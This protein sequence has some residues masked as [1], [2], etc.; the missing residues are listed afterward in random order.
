M[1]YD[2]GE[3]VLEQVLSRGDELGVGLADR[4]LEAKEY[5]QAG[6]VAITAEGFPWPWA[7]VID[8]PLPVS[9]P[10]TAGSAAVTQGSGTVTLTSAPAVGLGSFAGRKFYLDGAGTVY[11]ILAHTAGATTFTL[12]ANG[13]ATS[14]LGTTASG[15]FHIVKDVYDLAA[16]FLR[17]LGKPFLR[18]MSGR[19]QHCT[20]LGRDEVRSKFAYPGLPGVPQMAAMSGPR[21]ITI[22][23]VPSADQLYLYDYLRHPTHGYTGN[24]LQFDGSANDVVIIDPPEDGQVLEFYALAHLL[25]DRNDPRG[26]TFAEATVVKLND[27]KRLGL[28][29][30]RPRAWV[31]APYRVSVPR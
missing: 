28:K 23:A 17:P 13:T 18:D 30:R 14:Y 25:N 16:N 1:S 27:M 22:G 12:G 4:E 10:Y 26:R 11:P 31:S 20:L 6:L 3:G 5:I 15:A 24:R 9:G 29:L 19:R 7:E 21:R 8:Q 2:Q